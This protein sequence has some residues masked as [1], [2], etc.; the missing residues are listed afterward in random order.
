QRRFD[1][2]HAI[3]L[4][5]ASREP[6][7]RA[8]EPVV[9]IVVD[10]ATFEAALAAMAAGRPFDDATPRGDPTGYRCETIDGVPVDPCDA[11]TAALIGQVRR[12]VY[13]AR[14]CVIDLGTSSRLFRGSARLA[15][16]LQG[17]RCIWPGCGLR[18]C[19]IDHSQPWNGHGHTNPANGTPLC[20]RHNRWKTRGYQTARDADGRW[21]TYRPDGTEIRPT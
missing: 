21:H 14:S 15:V 20:G 12:V 6:G 8:P 13:G 19:E 1:A 18:Y 2:L 5:A 9:N 11:V 3:F 7:S 10:Q 4:A 16:W 17:T